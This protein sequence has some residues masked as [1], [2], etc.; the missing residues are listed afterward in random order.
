[1][2]DLDHVQEIANALS[3]NKL[4]TALTAFGVSWGIFLLVIMLAG[5]SGLENGARRDFQG[6]ATNSFFV[7]TQ[8]TSKPYKGL[9]RGRSFELTNDDVRAIR[10]SIPEVHLVSPR[11]QLRGYRG[12]SEVVRGTRSVGLAVMGDTP[13]VLQIEPV[14]VVK[15]RFLNPLDLAERRKVAVI[16]PRA[17]EVLFAKGEE[18]HRSEHPR[19]GCGLQGHRGVRADARGR[20]PRARRGCGLYTHHHLPACLQPRRARGLALGHLG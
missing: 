2:F 1:M 5:G 14:R 19:P 10:Q 11:S 6:T 13:D 12:G 9:P 7:W 4:R 18:S 8:R 17:V 16:G 3:R 20:R 15:G